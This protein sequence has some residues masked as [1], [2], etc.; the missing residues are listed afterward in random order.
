MLGDPFFEFL[1]DAQDD[2]IRDAQQ[3]VLLTL[4][5]VLTAAVIG[6]AVAV[7]TYRS[8]FWSSLGI[9][10]AA[11]AFTIPSLALFGILAPILGF[12]L[13]TVF[14]ALVMYSLMP[15]IRNGVV[16]LRGVDPVLL[17]AARGM[18]MNR[19]RVLVRIELPLAWPVILT[20]IRVSTQLA[21]GLVAIAAFLN[22]P[23]L[24]SEIW[25][26]MSNRGSYN[27]YN[28]ALGWSLAIA[29]VAILF[30]LVLFVVR[31]LTTPRGIRV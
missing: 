12:G 14:P 11:V 18:G 13:S 26:A 8:D 21:V 15:M 1:R 31:R 20:G 2:L 3:H 9:S 4:Y 23:G 25:S 17:D 28:Y 6:I 10:G 29:V 22:G 19:W 27:T 30:D 5:V 7:F 16:G 24:G